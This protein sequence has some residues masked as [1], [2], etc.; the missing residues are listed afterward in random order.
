MTAIFGDPIL[1]LESREDLLAEGLDPP[2]G[3]LIPPVGQIFPKNEFFS[4]KRSF[5]YQRDHFW[6]F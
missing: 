2:R 3:G 6:T 5:G 4:I 1:G